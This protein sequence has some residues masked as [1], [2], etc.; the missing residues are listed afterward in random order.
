[1]WGYEGEVWPA[2]TTTG[3]I[4]RV[5]IALSTALKYEA[6]PFLLL[7]SAHRTSPVSSRINR[8]VN[9]VTRAKDLCCYSQSSD[10]DLC[11]QCGRSKF[12]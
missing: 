7:Y 11:S 10:N 9:P 12:S 1:M 2:M 3:F 4:W 6:R 8:T 5:T